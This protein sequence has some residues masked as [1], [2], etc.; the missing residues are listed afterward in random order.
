VFGFTLLLSLLSAVLFGLAPAV[1]GS[2]ADVSEALKQ[3]GRSATA[4]FGR[5]RAG[6]ILVIGQVAL[7]LILLIGAGLMINSFVR[8]RGINPGF[9]TNKV[10]AIRLALQPAKFF[11]RSVL[12]DNTKR[13]GEGVRGALGGLTIW[14][15]KPELAGFV[16]RALQRL[17]SLPGVESAAVLNRTSNNTLPFGGIG[18]EQQFRIEGRP[19]PGPKQFLPEAVCRHV[20]SE[21]FRTMGIRLLQGRSFTDRD[22]QD[23]PGVV[24]I[25]EATA[26]QYWP[27][28]N[29]IGKR[30]W[31]RESGSIDE[32]RAF[33]IVG[34]AADVRQEPDHTAWPEIY[35][36]FVQH[37][38]QYVWFTTR[39]GGVI[40]LVR[41]SRDPTSLAAAAG[42][43]IRQVDPDQ[44]VES[45][46]T[47]DQYVA[48]TLAPWRR[49]MFLLGIFAGLALTLS[50]VGIYG[51]I[52]YSV[53]QR[54]HEIGIRMA[55]GAQARDVRSL[56]VGQGL[57]LTLK[58]LAIGAIGAYWLTRLISKQLFGVSPTDPATFSIVALLLT[59]VALL[60]SFIPVRRA[61]KI[62][63]IVALRQ[64]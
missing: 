61:T 22:I 14:T 47:M 29:P 32:Q 60:A 5:R 63:P 31:S 33:E 41:T 50:T 25:N 24:V 21:Y 9:D 16:Q 64:D 27:Q 11:E 1:R 46:E 52:S 48:T 40:F 19:L 3:A 28:E 43:A 35:I 2:N 6:G 20:S 51:V 53:A 62:D 37:N 10:L 34:I 57:S 7:T 30:I 58:G 15:I 23:A 38:Q 4:S 49:L 45:I 42:S 59:A 17:E 56:V 44:P 26:R 39:G 36:P 18:Y 54:T 55:L 13:R 12:P 8:L